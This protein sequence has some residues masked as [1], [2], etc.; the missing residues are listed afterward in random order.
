MLE[1]NGK[2]IFGNPMARDIILQPADEHDMEGMETETAGVRRLL[3]S[4]PASAGQDPG[5]SAAANDPKSTDLPDLSDDFCIAVYPVENWCDDLSPW[6]ADPVF[7]DEP[8]GEGAP[9]TLRKILDL[10]DTIDREQPVAGGHRFFLAGYSLAGF[11]ALWAACNT[12]RFTGVAGVSPSMWFPGFAEYLK[13]HL[14]QTRNVYL[15]L[16]LKEERTRHPVMRTV[17]DRIREAEALLVQNGYNVTLEW[18]PG[19]HFV[20]NDIRCAKGIAWL[21][22]Q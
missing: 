10:C 8:F 6:K 19:N 9:E 14:P 22:G 17:G 1:H 20:E 16:G 11:F 13:E 21:L 12:D 4:I 2:T 15:S 18:N 5:Q 3:K 7:G